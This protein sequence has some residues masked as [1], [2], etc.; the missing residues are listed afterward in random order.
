MDRARSIDEQSDGFTYLDLMLRG[1]A[2]D[3]TE[4]IYVKH[5]DVRRQILAVLAGH[6]DIDE[7]RREAIGKRGLFSRK[8]LTHPVVGALLERLGLAGAAFA[9]LEVQF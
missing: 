5:K 6:G 1:E 4:L 7:Q 9:I 2:Y 8:M 3:E